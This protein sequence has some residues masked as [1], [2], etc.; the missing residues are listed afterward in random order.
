MARLFTESDVA[1]L[2]RGA[3]LA[4]G[5]KD[6]ATPSALDL[7]H[8]RG[9]RVVR[10]SGEAS[11]PALGDTLWQRMLAEDATYV[12]QVVAG[13]PVVTRLT[14]AGPVPFQ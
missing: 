14:S 3:E 2:P 6:I 1:K 11:S 5:P 8:L 13:R 4:L 9:V 12:V 10:G 7:A